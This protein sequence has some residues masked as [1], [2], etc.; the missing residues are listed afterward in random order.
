M[1]LCP[2]R[3]VRRLQ[4]DDTVLLRTVRHVDSLV[5]GQSIDLSKLVVNVSTQRTDAIRIKRHCFG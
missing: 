4:L 3:E 1:E 2:L 5:D